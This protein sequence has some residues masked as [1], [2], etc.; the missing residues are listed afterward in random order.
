MTIRIGRASGG[1]GFTVTRDATSGQYSA[2][3][4]KA[5][6]AAALFDITAGGAAVETVTVSGGGVAT[7]TT[8]PTSGHTYVVDGVQRI[9]AGVAGGV[10]AP[11]PFSFGPW[12]GVNASG[13]EN[14]NRYEA[15]LGLN[16]VEGTHFFVPTM[17]AINQCNNA[18]VK[19]YR[20]PFLLERLYRSLG[21]TSLDAGYYANLVTTAD[22]IHSVGGKISWDCHAYGEGWFNGVKYN[23]SSTGAYNKTHLL[24]L[25]RMFLQGP[26]GTHPATEA[27]DLNNEWQALANPAD[28]PV[29]QQYIIDQLRADGSEIPIIYEGDQYSNGEHFWTINSVGFPMVDLKNKARPSGHIYMDPDSDGNVTSHPTWASC[30]AGGSTDDTPL[31]RI[32]SFVDNAPAGLQLNMG[33]TTIYSDGL[34]AFYRA[35]KYLIDHGHSGYIWNIGEQ[36]GPIE[37]NLFSY[38]GVERPQWEVIREFTGVPL[39]TLTLRAPHGADAGAAATL[40]IR[41]SGY[42]ATAFPVTLSD[43]GAGG[44]FS[45][46]PVT[47]PVGFGS[48]VTVT[49]TQPGTKVVNLSLTN[50]VGRTN[51]AAFAF[52]TDPANRI[53][54]L[55][56]AP[57]TWTDVNHATFDGATGTLTEDG[58]NDYHYQRLPVVSVASGAVELWIDFANTST[59]RTGVLVFGDTFGFSRFGQINFDLDAG[60]ITATSGAGLISSSIAPIAGGQRLKMFLDPGPLTEVSLEVYLQSGNSYQGSGQFL[61]YD[62]SSVKIYQPASIGTPGVTFPDPAAVSSSIGGTHSTTYGFEN[63]TDV[64]DADGGSFAKRFP[65]S[66]DQNFHGGASSATFVVNQKYTHEMSVHSVSNTGFLIL[67][68][69]DGSVDHSV[70][71]DL[72][73]HTIV[74]SAGIVTGTPKVTARDHGFYK[75][76]FDF[77]AAGSGGTG[78]E[79]QWYVEPVQRAASDW[80]GPSQSI[81]LD[82]YQAQI[83]PAT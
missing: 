59:R 28:L 57:T 31:N 61:R 51:P 36:S 22:R 64:T 77:I 70:I 47:V 71:Y 2:T 11:A 83:K 62:P 81:V 19:H 65:L 5:G 35:L 24:A 48:E 1:G 41:A 73:N 29:I 10:S 37:S 69:Y 49:Y 38:N 27:I 12:I 3:G 52:S 54:L 34:E 26:L 16:N 45:V 68:S 25:W 79:R 40:K 63:L 33:E 17:N 55:T 46:N 53:N 21:A 43:G 6:S 18:G 32:K 74:A 13:L 23:I 7:F 72:A 4:L 66:A 9:P 14:G 60:T 42:T 78:Y 8:S 15:S 56:S 58:N 30:K 50:A 44:T 76:E 82:C 80:Q 20:V 67:D 39:R 75:V